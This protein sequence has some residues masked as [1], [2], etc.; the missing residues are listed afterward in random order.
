M[1]KIILKT[2]FDDLYFEEHKISFDIDKYS[3]TNNLYVGMICW[4]NEYPEPWGDLTV[5][6]DCECDENCSYIDTNDNG[7]D[8]VD[9]LIENNLGELTGRKESSGF[10]TYPEFRFNIEELKKYIETI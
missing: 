4:D 9:W 2:N 6:L 10:C 7:N 3:Y 5:N 1:S 8:I